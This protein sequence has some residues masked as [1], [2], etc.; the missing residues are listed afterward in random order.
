MYNRKKMFKGKLRPHIAANLIKKNCPPRVDV[1]V[2]K[3]ENSFP[4]NIRFD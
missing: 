4:G 2:E 1:F 3:V